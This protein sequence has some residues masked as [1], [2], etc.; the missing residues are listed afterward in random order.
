MSN[1]EILQAKLL[2]LDR[3]LIHFGVAPCQDRK[4]QKNIKQVAHF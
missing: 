4:L 3:I 1:D 2:L